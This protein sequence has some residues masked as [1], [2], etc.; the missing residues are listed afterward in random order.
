MANLDFIEKEKFEDLFEMSGGYVLDF[1]NRTFQEFVYEKINLDIY[2]TYSSLS[3]AKILRRIMREKDNKT[4]GKLL[5]ELMRYMQAHNKINDSNRELF[6]QCAE[7]GH[8]L[9]G[10]TTNVQ[11]PKVRKETIQPQT[12]DYDFFLKKLIDLSNDKAK[13]PQQKGYEFESIIFQLF[14]AA[15]LSPRKSYKINGEQIDGSFVLDNEI[16]LLETKW[17]STEIGKNELS[18]FNSKVQSKSRLSRGLFISLSNYT[19]EAIDTFSNGT[20][21]CIVLMTVQELAMVLQKKIPI[22]TIIKDKIRMLAE[23]GKPYKPMYY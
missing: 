17:T 20:I 10:K 13:T 22:Q 2:K 19:S 16:Y 9:I 8:R 15:G 12:I 7:I 18:Y 21:V 1:T 6:Q 5:L 14:K 3:K 4:V 23:E 11:Q